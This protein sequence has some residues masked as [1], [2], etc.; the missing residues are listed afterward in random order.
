MKVS[1]ERRQLCSDV[2]NS[3][4]IEARRDLER[5]KE[6][7]IERS[8]DRAFRYAL[9]TAMTITLVVMFVDWWRSL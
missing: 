8:M 9:L 3:A 1:K 2:T 6:K 7:A 5:R 4:E